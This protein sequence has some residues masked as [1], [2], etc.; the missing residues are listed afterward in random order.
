MSQ[1]TKEVS[2]HDLLRTFLLNLA[3]A[4]LHCNVSCLIPVAY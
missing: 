3:F 1:G 2:L 4:S